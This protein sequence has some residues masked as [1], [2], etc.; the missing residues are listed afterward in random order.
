MGKWHTHRIPCE[1]HP[2]CSRA[3]G[4]RYVL[5]LAS[6]GLLLAFG[7]AGIARGEEPVASAVDRWQPLV[8][9]GLGLHNQTVKING[10]STLGASGRASRAILTSFIGLNGGLQSPAITTSFGGPRVYV[11]GGYKFPIAD[12]PRLL[13][14]DTVYRAAEYQADPTV[15]GANVTVGT[16]S[17]EHNLR[18]DLQIKNLWNI[19]M[20][21]EFT[22]PIEIQEVKLELGLE[23][24]GEELQYTAAATRVDR[25]VT[26]GGGNG[27]ILDTVTLPRLVET[28][29]I[30]SL[31]PRSAVSINVARMGPFQVN[32]NVE[33]AFYLYLDDYD[34]DFGQSTATDSQAFRVRSKEAFITQAAGGVSFVW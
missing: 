5:A 15:C 34:T 6:Y 3:R 16:R 25:G 26:V 32:F 33:L 8:Q 31:G 21:V 10:G 29:Y 14:E 23:Y 4:S 20:G 9:L 12:D 22:L 27:Q 13:D 17:C 2:R 1:I 11:R 30:H 19:G 24:L 7:L 18:M 28:D